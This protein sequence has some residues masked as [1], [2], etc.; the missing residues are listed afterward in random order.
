MSQRPP[1][2]PRP[3]GRRRG[4]AGFD[5]IKAPGAARPSEAS[6]AAGERESGRAALFSAAG[7]DPSSA[8]T[9]ALTVAAVHCRRCDATSPLDVLTAL[10][11]MLP[12][13]VL[14]W[15]DHPWWAVCPACGRRGW[16]RPELLGGGQR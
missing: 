2:G 3:P 14:P 7:A 15:A 4:P 10:R 6:E 5:R 11:G 9:R 1:T 16:L 13:V 8:P 12:L